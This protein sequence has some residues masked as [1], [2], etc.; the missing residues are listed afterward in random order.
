MTAVL[1]LPV[2][3]ATNALV[4]PIRTMAGVGATATI[5]GGGSRVTV[6][7][8]DVSTFATKVARTVTTATAGRTAGAVKTPPELIVPLPEPP[9]TDHVT[10]VL[11]L[12]VTVAVNNFVVP[13]CTEATFGVT[14]TVTEGG[15]VSV[16]V[17]LAKIDE[18]AP[19][20]AQ[21]VTV[22]EADIKAG[23]VYMP[24]DVI[25][26]LTE[27]PTTDH[28]T[29]V[30]AL[31]VTVAVKARELP[32]CTVAVVGATATVSVTTVTGTETLLPVTAPG[33]G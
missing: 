19:E 9:I 24:P 14:A 20:V 31:P 3:V 33:P 7:F 29:A 17:E 6:A 30:F 16:T 32:S 25:E 13:T 4:L 27:P 8:A 22:A 21:T 5:T 12:P 11:G 23:A 1:A 10:A 18:M 28:V 15:W 2:T 26:P